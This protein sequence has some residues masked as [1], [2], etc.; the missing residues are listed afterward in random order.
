MSDYFKEP[1]YFEPAQANI[2]LQKYIEEMRE[3]LTKSVKQEVESL[4]ESNAKFRAENE[5]LQ[6]LVSDINYREQALQYKADNMKQQMR[7]ERLD[8]LFAE[9]RFM[10]FTPTTKWTKREKC[11]QCDEDRRI[12][13]QSPRGKPVYE[14][15]DC[16]KTDIFWFPIENLVYVFQ[17]DERNFGHLQIWYK[18]RHS[19]YRKDEMYL[20][21]DSSHRAEEYYEEGMDFTDCK[22]NKT[23]FTDRDMC[24]A[25]CDWL[26]SKKKE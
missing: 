3:V 11:D 8:E 2:V 13:F 22:E 19:E 7:K 6:R 12:W 14:D 5:K 10:L 24:Q 21:Y 1:E 20:D 17:L 16:S 23:H 4:R 9:F 25:Y 15:C 18:M 26:N